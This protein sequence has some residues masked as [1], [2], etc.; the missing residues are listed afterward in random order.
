MFFWPHVSQVYA[1]DKKGQRSFDA[2]RLLH[3]FDFEEADDGNFEDKPRFWYAMG[4]SEQSSN[5][6]FN[7]KPFNQKM[8]ARKGFPNYTTVKFNQPQSK[9]GPHNLHLGLNGG[10][11][12]AFVEVGAI[13]AVP[14]SDYMVTARIKTSALEYARA[15]LIVYFIDASGRRI[16]SS[17]QASDLLN[18]ANSWEQVTIKLFGNHTDAAWIGMQ[19]ELLQPQHQMDFERSVA[20][21]KSGKHSVRYQQVKGDA[22]F[23]DIAIWQVPRVVVQTQSPVNLIVSP[24]Q[25]LLTLQVRDLIGQR[26][27]AVT[28]VYNHRHEVVA[29]TS[30]YV[31]RGRTSQWQWQ[32]GISRYGWYLV[33]LSLY[34]STGQKPAGLVGPN[35]QVT[36]VDGLT[37]SSPPQANAAPNK[38]VAPVALVNAGNTSSPAIPTTAVTQ[39]TKP[40]GQPRGRSISDETDAKQKVVPITRALRAFL[41]LP[42]REHMARHDKQ[43]FTVDVHEATGRELSLL[44]AVLKAGGLRSV[45]VSGWRRNTTSANIH[46]Q[47]NVLDQLLDPLNQLNVAIEVN[48]SPVPDEIVDRLGVNRHNPIWLFG[49]PIKNWEPFV[50]PMLMRQGQHVR[51]WQLGPS[52]TATT[53]LDDYLQ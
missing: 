4:R 38:P 33:D 26:M 47:Q 6:N 23:D 12:G 44:P 14:G 2:K 42:K 5:R 49:Q 19:V 20:T 50:K 27:L 30:R 10:S 8:M 22:W 51:R 28:T 7:S 3:L 16:E 31:G 24:Q 36:P 45:S 53:A 34:E 41:L 46:M 37:L 11:A 9:K 18:T 13:A 52:A 17:M 48:L 21:S 15:R 25:P 39:L 1:Q 29:K 43:R 35:G 40:A 32:P